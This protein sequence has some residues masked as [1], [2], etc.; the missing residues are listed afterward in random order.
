MIAISTELIVGV[1]VK[2]MFLGRCRMSN[3]HFSTTALRNASACEILECLR[4]MSCLINARETR[5]KR[6]YYIYLHNLRIKYQINIY[7]ALY[8]AYC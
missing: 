3:T 7:Y 6:C 4:R 2:G 1:L 8:S 5:T